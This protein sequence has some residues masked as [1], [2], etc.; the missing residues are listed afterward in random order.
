MPPLTMVTTE[1]PLQLS[2]PF[3]RW[4]Y[5]GVMSACFDLMVLVRPKCPF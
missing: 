1:S 4:A 3:K 2:S 5:T